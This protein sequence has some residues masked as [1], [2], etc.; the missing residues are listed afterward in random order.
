VIATL[1]TLQISN[2]KSCNLKVA[3]SASKVYL[4]GAVNLPVFAVTAVQEI[5]NG[6][7]IFS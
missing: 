1:H 3:F 6:S 2:S 7:F 5:E 4:D